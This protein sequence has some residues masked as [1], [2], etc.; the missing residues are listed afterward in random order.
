[1]VLAISCWPVTAGARVR[2]HVSLCEICC[3]HC[4]FATG[5]SSSILFFPVVSVIPPMLHTNLH[6]H[7]TFTKK[8]NGKSLK[9]FVKAMLYLKSGNT[10]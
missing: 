7:F 5:F 3:G 9:T 1:M 4:G 8:T 10:G 6:L 2:S